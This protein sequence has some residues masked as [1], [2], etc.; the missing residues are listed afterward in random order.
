MPNDQYIYKQ[1]KAH[2]SR[3]SIHTSHEL[4]GIA[5]IRSASMHRRGETIIDDPDYGR[6]GNNRIKMKEIAKPE[7]GSPAKRAG[8]NDRERKAE[9]ATS[10][11]GAP[12]SP[13]TSIHNR[14]ARAQGRW[15]GARQR[16][17]ELAASLPL[18]LP[19]AAGLASLRR[20]SS[21]ETCT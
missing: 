8:D 17:T 13:V 1:K 15:P 19:S 6:G 4:G 20:V 10:Q 5:H 21:T 9:R 14:L 2:C 18:P 11:C 7:N 16:P 3:G 12:V